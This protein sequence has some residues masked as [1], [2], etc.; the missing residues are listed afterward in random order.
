MTGQPEKLPLTAMRGQADTALKTAS[1]S[2]SGAS[3]AAFE[4]FYVCRAHAA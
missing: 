3:H 4:P 2:T 1:F